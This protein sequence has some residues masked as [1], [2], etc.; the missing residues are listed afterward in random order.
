MN[1]IINFVLLDHM[2]QVFF[3]HDIWTIRHDIIHKF[4]P[5][6][7]GKPLVIIHKRSTLTLRNGFIR[8]NPYH[9]M[10]PQRPRQPKS[11]HMTIMHHIKCPIHKNPNFPSIGHILIPLKQIEPLLQKMHFF[12]CRLEISRQPSS[13]LRMPLAHQ[14]VVRD[15]RDYNCDNGQN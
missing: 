14:K 10:R 3:T 1:N 2:F 4:T 15:Q 12:L 8:I 7:H 6:D 13:L 9:K 5:L 11:I